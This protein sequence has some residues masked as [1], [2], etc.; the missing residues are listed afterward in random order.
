MTN[1]IK[2]NIEGKELG[3]HFGLG[4]L[5]ELLDN[6]DIT[7]ESIESDIQNNPFKSIPKLMHTSYVY[8]LKRQEKASEL[9]F[10]EFL[11]LLDSAG[12]INCEGALLFIDAFGKS[13]NKDVPVEKNKIPSSGKKK[14]N[15]RK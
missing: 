15:P 11:D 12:G 1:K 5:G 7:I 9:N 3:F 10:F 8:N 6:S 4:F 14:A 2:L 13:M